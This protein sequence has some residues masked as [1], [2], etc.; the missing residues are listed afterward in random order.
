MH[1][2]IFNEPENDV[3]KR[4]VDKKPVNESKYTAAFRTKLEKH[5][6]PSIGVNIILVLIAMLIF[7]IAGSI[8][9]TA[10]NRAAIHYTPPHLLK[11][12][13]QKQS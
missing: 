13:T 8:Y 5:G 3:K 6:I 10:A 11:D 9:F 2:V 7:A 12:Y 4:T 1:P